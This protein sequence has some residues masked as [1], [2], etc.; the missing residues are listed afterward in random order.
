MDGEKEKQF[1][2][3]PARVKASEQADKIDSIEKYPDQAE[4]H[5][6]D[7]DED[8][9]R[10]QIRDLSQAQSKNFPQDQREGLFR[11]K[12]NFMYAPGEAIEEAAPLDPDIELKESLIETDIKFV[13]RIF[14]V[15]QN[16][17]L[18]SDGR[19][20]RREIV[21][22][23]G[24]ACVLAMDNNQNIFM[25]RQF[26][27]AFDRITLELPAG[28]LDTGEDPLSCAKRE[29]YEETGIA[30]EDWREL[31]TIM[32]TPGYSD[33][34][35]SIFLA[36]DLTRGEKNCDDGEFV[37]LVRLPLHDAMQMVLNG[38]IMDAKTCIGILLAARLA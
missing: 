21:R 22:H 19:H 1:D 28:K 6:Q 30:A 12:N 15:E 23:P 24:G 11:D 38:S 16:K 5:P 36:E 32:P 8:L 14:S 10:D 33:E 25:V 26:R 34:L 20:S 37:S 17:V 3:R 18:L 27:L 35:I 9:L 31:A 4:G 13:G 7:H 29:L 2:L